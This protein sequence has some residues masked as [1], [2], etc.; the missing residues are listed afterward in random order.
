MVQTS[1]AEWSK[2]IF[3]NQIDQFQI[4]NCYGNFKHSLSRGKQSSQDFRVF[5][6]NRFFDEIFN[7]KKSVEK[8]SE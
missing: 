8:M 6:T 1:I 7:L 3:K 4:H 5:V 2:L